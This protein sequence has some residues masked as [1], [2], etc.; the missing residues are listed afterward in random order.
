M[1]TPSFLGVMACLRN[2]S[3]EEVHEASPDPLAVGV[4]SA[5]WVVTMCTSHIVW[6]EMTGA[7]YMDTVTTMVGRVA[8]SGPEQE[9]LAQGPTIED[10]MDLI[11]RVARYLL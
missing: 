5:P 3:L 11:W 7:T 6:D 4:M 2:Q 8:L 1:P 9:M 10:V